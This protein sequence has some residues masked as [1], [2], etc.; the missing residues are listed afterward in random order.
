MSNKSFDYLNFFYG[1][2]AAI[3]LVAALFKF[4]GWRYAEELFLVGLT[5]EALIF[6]ISA[7]EWKS[8]RK[9]YAWERLFP[10]LVSDSEE[11]EA[12]HID[13]SVKRLVKQRHL[14]HMVQELQ[15]MSNAAEVLNTAAFKLSQSVEKA[16]HNYQQMSEVTSQYKEELERL[17][18]RLYTAN[19]VL[20]NLEQYTLPK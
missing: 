10:E 3:I 4:L 17:R 13:E 11:P 14:E 8:E 18:Q 19:F 6:L 12:T 15:A 9:P 16:D 5:G 2:G 20:D 7:F 1:L